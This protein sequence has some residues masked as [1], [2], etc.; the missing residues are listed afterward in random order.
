M[1]KLMF[2][3]A[4]RC[5]VGDRQPAGHR[6]RQVAD[7]IQTV[8]DAIVEL[9]RCAGSRQADDRRFGKTMGLTAPSSIVPRRS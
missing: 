1:K 7:A 8:N 4:G 5:S 9:D 3:N 6:A 2:V